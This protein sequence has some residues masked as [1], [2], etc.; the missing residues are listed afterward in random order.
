M[1]RPNSSSVRK[2]RRRHLR[3]ASLP[4]EQRRQVDEALDAQQTYQSISDMT[5]AW[6]PAISPSGIARYANFRKSLEVRF[7]AIVQLRAEKGPKSRTVSAPHRRKSKCSS[8]PADLRQ[9][10]NRRLITGLTYSVLASWLKSTGNAVSP[11]GVARYAD[12]LR[13]EEDLVG[14]IVLEAKTL[15]HKSQC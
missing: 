14:A 11:A 2:V 4:E 13:E 5:G 1:D 6:G 12:A 10:L 15:A 7:K 8:L 9:E 3:V